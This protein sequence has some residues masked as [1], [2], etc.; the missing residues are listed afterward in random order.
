MKTKTYEKELRKLQ[1]ELCN[2]QEWVKSKGLRV[3]DH[4]DFT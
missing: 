4:F 1:G 2:L 3:T